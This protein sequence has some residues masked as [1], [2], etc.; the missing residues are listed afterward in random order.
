LIDQKLRILIETLIHIHFCKLADEKRKRRE[1][2]IEEPI[3]EKDARDSG[4]DTSSYDNDFSWGG[5]DDGLD[6]VG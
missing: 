4:G 6:V 2:K 5:D 3:T 1:S